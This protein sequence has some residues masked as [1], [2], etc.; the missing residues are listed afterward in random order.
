MKNALRCCAL[1]LTLT[2]TA[3]VSFEPKILV[4]AITLSPEEV[5]LKRSTSTG[6]VD[7][8][9]NVTPNE[10]D[11]LFNIQSL[12]GVR[13]RALQPIHLLPKPALRLETSFCKSTKH[14]LITRTAFRRSKAC[15]RQVT[16]TCSRFVGTL[17][18]TKPPLRLYPLQ[19]S[20][21]RVNSTEPTHSPP[22]QAT[23]LSLS[24]LPIRALFPLRASLSCS[25]AAH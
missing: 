11:S 18:S 8:G 9:L 15:P 7:F 23:K 17:S 22:G 16:N 2:L 19:R 5:E 13:V 20:P 24:G 3:C 21:N 10:S 14:A 6:T 1:W 12:P 25:P 4:P